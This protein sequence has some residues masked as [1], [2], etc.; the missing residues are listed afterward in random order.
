[1]EHFTKNFL[2]DFFLSLSLFYNLLSTKRKCTTNYVL[3]VC[4]QNVLV[5]HGT[6]FMLYES[7]LRSGIYTQQDRNFT[8]KYYVAVVVVVCCCTFRSLSNKLLFFLFL[9]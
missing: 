6:Q 4:L 9:F 5:R 8:L 3:Y 2:N 7:D 1:M